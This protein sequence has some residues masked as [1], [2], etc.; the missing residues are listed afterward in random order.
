MQA[1]LS[2]PQVSPRTG[3]PTDSLNLPGQGVRLLPHQA[4]GADTGEFF[5]MDQ[6]DIDR[7]PMEAGR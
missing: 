6:A 7:A 4:C 2:Q 5:F 1:T 3:F